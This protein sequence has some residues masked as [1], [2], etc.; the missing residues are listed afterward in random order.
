MRARIFSLVAT[1]AL[2]V[3]ACG[4]PAEPPATEVGPPAAGAADGFP[5]S[6]PQE[7]GLLEL[8]KAPERVYVVDAWGLDIVV[9]LGVKP[10]GAAT[11]FP[12]SAW[13]ADAPELDG[14]EIATVTDSLPL[15][16][17]AATQPDLIVDLSG[18][19]SADEAMSGKLRQ[20]APVLY[21]PK[22]WLSDGWRERVHHAGAALGRAQAAEKMIAD[23]EQTFAAIRAEHPE[24]DGAALT[25]ARLDPPASFAIVTDDSDFTRR[26]LNTELGFTTPTA[27]RTAYASGT[28]D[29]VGGVMEGVSLERGDL[30]DANA[31]AALIWFRD[32]T[33][34]E[35]LERQPA[36]R[37]V[38]VVAEQRLV[39]MDIDAAIALRTPTPASIAWA[40]ENLIPDL[41]AAVAKADR[42]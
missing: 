9:G 41:A 11:Y 27:Q 13:L 18:S 37:Q 24:L 28:F 26:F 10:V 2:L 17:I 30:I 29:N 23:G 15:E 20:I 6:L 3:A 5:L 39:P 22:D 7:G 33:N 19:A 38:P 25:F 4:E 34:L 12:P 31:D 35:A 14:V 40:A 16:T 42:G 21:P 32:A 8:D 36:W 1:A